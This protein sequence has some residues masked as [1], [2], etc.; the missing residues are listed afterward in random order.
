MSK[1]T[2][3]SQSVFSILFDYFYALERVRSLRMSSSPS[4]FHTL[5]ENDRGY[6]IFVPRVPN[7]V[8]YSS[9]LQSSCFQRNYDLSVRSFDAC[10]WRR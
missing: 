4:K 3:I 8:I 2:T 9:Y 6:V 1:R 5:V 7:A 10:C